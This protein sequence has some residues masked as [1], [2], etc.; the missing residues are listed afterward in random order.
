LTGLKLEEYVDD[1]REAMTFGLRQ[2]GMDNGQIFDHM[3]K[4]GAWTKVSRSDVNGIKLHTDAVSQN[5]YLVHADPLQKI[6]AETFVELGGVTGESRLV[7]KERMFAYIKQDKK[8]YNTLKKLYESGLE[9]SD[10]AGTRG[11]LS[12]IRF[13]DL[14]SD[15]LDE[16]LYK[17][18]ELVAV[19]HVQEVTG[20]VSDIQFAYAF[21]RIPLR[22]VDGN[23]EDLIRTPMADVIPIDVEPI[24]VGTTVLTSADPNQPT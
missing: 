10:T 7:A 16:L 17:H 18:A 4:T 15:E 8:L 1:V 2:Q 6:A 5:G 23:L 20:N 22:D 11:R 24:R 19:N 13:D 9:V 12:P 3:V 14:P 21:N